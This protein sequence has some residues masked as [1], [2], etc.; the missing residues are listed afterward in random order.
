MT[1]TFSSSALRHGSARPSASSTT[2]LGRGPRPRGPTPA[3][4]PTVPP[5]IHLD[6]AEVDVRRAPPRR[7]V[8]GRDAVRL[9][10]HRQQQHS[11]RISEL[12]VLKS[13]DGHAGA[14]SRVVFG[15]GAVHVLPRGP[16]PGPVQVGLKPRRAGSVSATSS[17]RSSSA[18]Q[19]ST[20]MA[21]RDWRN[22]QNAR[23]SPGDAPS[24][25]AHPSSARR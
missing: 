19:S 7:G 24:N 2:T 17:A 16:P 25:A 9:P 12:A 1:S 10:H 8:H 18:T 11:G 13:H 6:E 15:A 14:G 4:R 22:R 23:Q 5:L 3:A 20:A 21:S